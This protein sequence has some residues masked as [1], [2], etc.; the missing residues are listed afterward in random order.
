[1]RP[2]DFARIHAAAFR[3]SRPWSAAEFEALLHSK[4]CFWV[5]DSHGFALGRTIAGESE[6]LTIAVAP[7][8]QG[9]GIGRRLL[10]EYHDQAHDVGATSFF[11]EVAQDNK[12]AINLYLSEGYLQSAVRKAYYARE[13]AA[14]VDALILRKD[15]PALS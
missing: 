1:M 8:D 10:R 3:E 7:D 6:L 9:K 13:D 15:M 12:A 14:P 4:H 5:G 11:L 2:E